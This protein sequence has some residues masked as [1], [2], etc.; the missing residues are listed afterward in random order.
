MKERHDHDSPRRADCVRTTSVA[1]AGCSSSPGRG[2]RGGRTDARPV[3]RYAHGQASPP[4]VCS[5]H[6]TRSHVREAQRTKTH[7]RRIHREHAQ[8]QQGAHEAG[9]H[10]VDSR[11]DHLSGQ[12]RQPVRLAPLRDRPADARRDRRSRQ[13]SRRRPPAVTE[14]VTTDVARVGRQRPALAR[15][16]RLNACRM[17]VPLELGT[18]LLMS[19]PPATAPE[20]VR[21]LRAGRRDAFERLY[22]EYSAPIY[23]LCARVVCDREEAKDLTQDVFITAFD[24]LPA[25]DAEPVRKL[26]ALAL[27]RGHERLLQ[28]PA[29]ARKLDRGGDAGLERRAS[30]VDEYQR[31]ETVALVEAVARAAERALPHRPRAQGPPGPGA[32]RDRRGD[33]GLAAERRRARAPRQGLVQDRLRQARRRRRRRPGRTRPCAHAAQPAG[34]AAGRCR[35]CPRTLPRRTPCPSPTSPRPPAPPAPGCSAR[36]APPSRPRSA[37]TAAAA[38]VVIGGGAVA[39]KEAGR[40]DRVAGCGGCGDRGSRRRRLAASRRPTPRCTTDIGRAMGR[41]GASTTGPHA[42]RGRLVDDSG[43]S[44]DGAKHDSTTTTHERVMPAAAPPRRT[45]PAAAPRRRRTTA[46]PSATDSTGSSFKQHDDHPDGWRHVGEPRRRL[47]R[48][49][50]L[51]AAT[52][53]NEASRVSVVEADRDTEEAP[54]RASRSPRTGSWS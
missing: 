8:A 18:P 33:G 2:T 34:R 11:P 7:A 14:R 41:R 15:R 17:R 36:S 46:A 21:G 43:G 1:M 30:G 53:R 4:I 44:H 31:A 19:S 42:T 32:R 40:S 49:A 24:Q 26:Q 13:R 16:A 50:R 52:V 9:A 45:M 22:G 48:L 25:T 10:D 37:V 12:L 38:T 47:G 20:L 6:Q 3:R 28:P 54:E 51:V 27:P 5:D 23:N 35:R 29:L 39:V